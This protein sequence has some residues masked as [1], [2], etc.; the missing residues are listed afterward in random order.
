MFGVDNYTT[1]VKDAFHR[2]MI[3]GEEDATK[4]DGRGTKVTALYALKL[5]AGESF[6]IKI[7]LDNR[8]D[9]ESFESE[10]HFS[11]ENFDNIVEQRILDADDFYSKVLSGIASLLLIILNKRC[12]KLQKR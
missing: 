7:K 3:D 4:P 6:K 5:K 10:D 11:A 9:C 1:Y 8:A 12:C 2:Y